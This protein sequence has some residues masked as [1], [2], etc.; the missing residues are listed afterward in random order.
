MRRLPIPIKY[1]VLFGTAPRFFDVFPDA[2]AVYIPKNWTGSMWNDA[3]ANGYHLTEGGTSNGAMTTAL[4]RPA[5]SGD[6]AVYYRNTSFISIANTNVYTAFVGKIDNIDTSQA[7]WEISVNSGSVISFSNFIDSG[8]LYHRTRDAG[9]NVDLRFDDA[10]PYEGVFE[11]ILDGFV[12]KLFMNG[13]LVAVEE[14]GY[15][16]SATDKLTLMGWDDFVASYGYKSSVNEFGVIRRLPSTAERASLLNGVKKYYTVDRAFNL[17]VNTLVNFATTVGVERAA[18]D[19]GID[20]V[21]FTVGG[22]PATNDTFEL[23]FRVISLTNYLTA[24]VEYNGSDWDLKVDEV[25][26]TPAN[27]QSATNVGTPEGI[28]VFHEA[29]RIRVWLKVSG[30]WSLQFLFDEFTHQN[31]AGVQLEQTTTGATFTPTLFT[32]DNIVLA[33]AAIVNP[34]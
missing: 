6:G 12:T 34:P 19:D 16:A 9:G 24:Y 30:A 22:T 23:R 17:S 32:S 26:S 18:F 4:G 20:T 7:L 27:L 3:T 29:G 13:W 11:T 15:V 2:D 31:N 1:P 25:M 5:I 33:N 10:I 21:E 14:T 28:K 8:D